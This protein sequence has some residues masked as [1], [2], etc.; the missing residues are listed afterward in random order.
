[1]KR[2][3]KKTHRPARQTRGGAVNQKA[4]SSHRTPN[5]QSDAWIELPNMLA[6]ITPCGSLE[7]LEYNGTTGTLVVFTPA[8]VRALAPVFQLGGKS[9]KEAA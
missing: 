1:M 6:R 4:V 2:L 3:D 8:D 7:I 9:T 5:I